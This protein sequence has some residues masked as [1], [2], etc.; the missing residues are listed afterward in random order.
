MKYINIK[1][2]IVVLSAGFVLLSMSGCQSEE[3][4]INNKDKKEISN[5]IEINPEVSSPIDNFTSDDIVVEKEE[6]IVSYF[7]NLE[8]EVDD[9]INENNF[10]EVKDKAKNIAITGIDFLFYEKEINGITFEELTDETK[11]KIINIVVSID[12]KIENRIPGYKDTVK[13]KFG[14]SYGYVTDKLH[15]GLEYVDDKLE[16]KYGEKY[17]NVKEKTLGIKDEVKD[18]VSDVWQE[19][20]D[21][22]SSGWSK[23][24]DRY[25]EKTNKR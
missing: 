8:N 18:T 3:Q 2:I 7:E 6:E 11:N 25:E 24:K 15:Q 23:L 19:V 1:K 14:K 5:R 12:N 4:V 16:D 20:K 10:D 21:K 9:Y 13:D 17:D 22:T